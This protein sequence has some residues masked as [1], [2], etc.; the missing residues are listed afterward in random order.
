MLK[1]Y[2]H[3]SG[4]IPTAVHPFVKYAPP[5]Q[6]KQQ[7]QFPSRQL[8]RGIKNLVARLLGFKPRQLRSQQFERRR[9]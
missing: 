1:Q 9:E 4:Q 8:I 6:T 5:S 3:R 2:L 7:A